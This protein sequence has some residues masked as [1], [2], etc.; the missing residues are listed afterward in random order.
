[1]FVDGISLKRQWAGEVKNASV[2]VAAGM[3]EDG[4]REVIGIS[5]RCKEDKA[6][7]YQFLQDLRRRGLG[8]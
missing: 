1:M 4:R 7:W 8:R 5:E 2:L 3:S 6:G